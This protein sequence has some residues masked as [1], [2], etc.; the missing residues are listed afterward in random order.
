MIYESRLGS[1]RLLFADSDAAVR[2]AMAQPFLLKA[3]VD[4]KFRKHIPHVF[5][6]WDGKV[7]K[8][9]FDDGLVEPGTGAAAEL[10]R[11]IDRKRAFPLGV[12]FQD[13]DCCTWARGSSLVRSPEEAD[14]PAW[15]PQHEAPPARSVRNMAP[16]RDV[17][18]A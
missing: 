4:G 8:L 17:R 11:C 12:S 18:R 14:D 6:G 5:H 13:S 2:S 10:P 15:S 7:D 16:L 3:E 1:A 9:Y